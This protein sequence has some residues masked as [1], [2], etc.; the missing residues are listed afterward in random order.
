MFD[1]AGDGATDG[2]AL[3]LL[4]AVLAVTSGRTIRP[5]AFVQRVRPVAATLVTGVPV[6]GIVFLATTL[7]VATATGGHQ[8]GGHAEPAANHGSAAHGT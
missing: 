1:G 5:T 2:G 7:A 6:I 4:V 3:I 8:D